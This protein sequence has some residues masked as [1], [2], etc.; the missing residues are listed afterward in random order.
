MSM[1]KMR[2]GAGGPSG[3]SAES[4]VMSPESEELPEE[5]DIF[6]FYGQRRD[7]RTKLFR[8][9]IEDGRPAERGKDML[10]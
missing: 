7:D 8:P 9:A 5:L 1:C 2:R 4:P 10:R 6:Y 3:F